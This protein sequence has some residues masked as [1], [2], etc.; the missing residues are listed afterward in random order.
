MELI[1]LITKFN[2]DDLVGFTHETIDLTTQNQILINRFEGPHDKLIDLINKDVSSFMD[3]HS[4]VGFLHF[5]SPDESIREKASICDIMMTNYSNSLNVSKDYFK[6]IC[7]LEDKVSDPIDKIFLNKIKTTYQKNGVHLHPENQNLLFRIKEEIQKIESCFI[8]SIINENQKFILLSEENVQGL[9]K[10][11]LEGLEMA[12]GEYKLNLNTH[13]YEVIMKYLHNSD[14]RKKI[15]E[16]YGTRC[17]SI[18]DDITRLFILRHKHAQLLGFDCHSNYVVSEQMA[19]SSENIKNFLMDTLGR[20]DNRYFKE[21]KKLIEL[22]KKDFEAGLIDKFDNDLHSWEVEYYTMKWKKKYGLNDSDV[23][24]YF[25]FSNTVKKIIKLYQD[26]FGVKFEK[27][28]AKL[29]VDGLLTYKVLYN[30]QELGYVILDLLKRD[31]KVAHTRCCSL[32]QGDLYKLPVVCLTGSFSKNQLLAH[33]QV[34]SLF[35]EF[36]HVM[37][38]LFGRTKYSIL[39]GTNCE[40]DFVEAPAQILENLCWEPKILKYISAHYETGETLPDEIIKKMIKIKDL[41][42]GFHFKKH[43]MISIYDQ[44]IHSS[45]NF[46]TK[47]EDILRIKDGQETINDIKETLS[48]MYEIIHNDMMNI[49]PDYTIDFLDGTFIPT[50]WTNLASGADARYYNYVW[51]KILSSDI[52]DSQFVGKNVKTACN[53]LVDNIFVHGGS[54][55]A[56]EMVVDYLGRYPNVGGFLKLNNLVEMSEMSVF[57]STVNQ[58]HVGDQFTKFQQKLDK[59]DDYYTENTEVINAHVDELFIKKK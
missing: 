2:S 50:S 16:I 4:I 27:Y 58:P 11:Y 54:K 32:I 1:E 52:Y 33:S 42:I 31:N 26:M 8:T 41:N 56:K 55:K 7:K 49:H 15:A 19:K 25:S 3:M 6:V 28:E 38:N 44:I 30:G 51:N 37:H 43:I 10:D 39:S 20:L 23:R 48:S 12:N 46:I 47:L 21:L 59:D 35:H 9:P 5:V 45:N 36:G 13:T 29:W 22:K 18:L 24:E 57:N 40:K 14:I 17:E 53:G 34:C